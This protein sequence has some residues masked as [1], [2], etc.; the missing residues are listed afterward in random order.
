MKDGKGIAGLLN[1]GN[2]ICTSTVVSRDTA[3]SWESERSPDHK[4]QKE[5]L[6]DAGDIS[7]GQGM[8][9]LWDIHSLGLRTH[10]IL[11][12]LSPLCFVPL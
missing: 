7:G 6:Q 10:L 5:N 4:E 3:H 8:E 1:I 9:V 11:H 12:I 2:K